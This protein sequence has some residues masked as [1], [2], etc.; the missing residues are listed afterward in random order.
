M[1]L[2]LLLQFSREAKITD[3]RIDGL[4]APTVALLDFNAGV[5]NQGMALLGDL[6]RDAGAEPEVFDVRI[7]GRLPE[8]KSHAAYL[9]SGGPG[10]PLD[11]Q[12]WQKRTLPFLRTLSAESHVFGV[13]M[14]FQLLAAAHGWS[15]RLL[16][17]GHFGL[18]PLN[19]LE[20]GRSDRA[21]AEVSPDAL[22]FEQRRWGVFPP[23]DGTPPTGVGLSRGPA[24]DLTG[25]RFT[26]SCAGVVFHPEA[27][28]EAI[29]SFFT[30]D[31][32]ARK[33]AEERH[34]P[35]SADQMAR[36]AHRLESTW[37]GIL[38]VF[39]SHALGP[40]LLDSNQRKDA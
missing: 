20:P 8:P 9:L 34:G 17:S 30:E 23:E 13:C 16:P 36:E 3:S 27:P 19:R 31:Q 40:N 32:T 14:G 4:M 11:G 21:L 38:P 28:P 6:I 12:S 5:P 25:I 18:Y 35:G 2:V 15:L 10:A 29:V 1:P 39:L 24:G 33:K 26:P 7:E 37:R 22:A